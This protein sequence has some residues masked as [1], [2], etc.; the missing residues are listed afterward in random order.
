MLLGSRHVKKTRRS[1]QTTT[2]DLSKVLKR[3]HP[4]QG[5]A[6]EHRSK[7]VEKAGDFQVGR[8]VPTT[9]RASKITI[10]CSDIPNQLSCQIL[11]ICFH[12]MLMSTSLYYLLA[13]GKGSK[14]TAALGWLRGLKAHSGSLA[15]QT[16]LRRQHRF[17]RLRVVRSN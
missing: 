15:L 5:R 9:V 12:T 17:P 16:H 7:G 3:N 1:F 13:D 11:Q 10:F 4:S 8:V 6:A 2:L 14:R